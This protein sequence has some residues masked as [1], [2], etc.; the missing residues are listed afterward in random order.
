MYK[1]PLSKAHDQSK[2]YYVFFLNHISSCSTC[3]DDNN[4]LARCSHRI[5]LLP[6]V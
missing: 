6:I 4:T 5:K 1:R 2:V 3:L